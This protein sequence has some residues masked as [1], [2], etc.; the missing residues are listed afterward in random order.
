MIHA[1]IFQTA[2]EINIY[3]G[4]KVAM[5][6]YGSDELHATVIT[7]KNLYDTW[8]GIFDFLWLQSV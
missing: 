7:S 1:D 2:S 4:N 8:K 6:M 5:L 3:G